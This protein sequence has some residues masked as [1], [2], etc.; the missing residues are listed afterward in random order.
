LFLREN[1]R[2]FESSDDTFLLD[3]FLRLFVRLATNHGS[4]NRNSF[5]TLADKAAKFAPCLIARD[6]AGIGPLSGNQEKIVPRVFREQRHSLEIGRERF[7]VATFK[8]R[9]QLLQSLV[10]DFLYFFYFHFFVLSVSWDS[11]PSPGSRD[12]GPTASPEDKVFGCEAVGAGG[13]GLATVGFRWRD[14]GASGE[15]C[16][17]AERCEAVAREIAREESCGELRRGYSITHLI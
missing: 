9:N 5:F 17:D 12:R 1:V 8:S 4:N 3:W 6:S 2:H 10:C 14:L 16:L 7:A 15:R 11:V 13:A